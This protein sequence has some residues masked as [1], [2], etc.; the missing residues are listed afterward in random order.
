MAFDVGAAIVESAPIELRLEN[1]VEQALKNNPGLKAEK[2]RLKI[3]SGR[4]Q[5]AKRLF[6]LN[7]ELTLD[8]DYRQR[9]FS[10]PSGKSGTDFELRLLQE[11]ELSG[12]RHH[13]TE[14][15]ENYLEAAEWRF[16]ETQRQLRLRVAHLFYD[17]LTLQEKIK[18]QKQRLAVHE[19]LFNA[20]QLRF[21]QEDI[22]VLEIDTLR[23]DREQVRH[24]LLQTKAKKLVIEK[25]LSSS[26]GLNEGAAFV[27][28]GSLSTILAAQGME[29][30]SPLVEIETCALKHRP[31]LKAIQASLEGDNGAFQLALSQKVPNLSFGPLFKSDNQDT[32]I[33]ASLIIPLP[34]FNR[35]QQEVTESRVNLDVKKIALDTKKREIRREVAATYRRLK[36]T[37]DRFD[38][39]GKDY[40][41]RLKERMALPQK[42]YRAGEISIFE[43]SVAQGRLVDA[44][45]RYFDILQ[46]LLKESEDL[47]SQM[48]AC[49]PTNTR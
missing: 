31:D 22:S 27:V 39:Y 2:Q 29:I 9:K 19:D 49:D 42:A 45:L 12:Q 35:N 21:Q 43:F 23:F 44:Q 25:A 34:F 28:T 36:L 20:G 18:I 16:T 33:G 24:D 41:A 1:A 6:Q 30:S 40:L 47:N 5:Q 32:V 11:I 38:Y 8:A 4:L 48:G 15:A 46:T 17:L 10:S 13:R 14:A 37:R 7:P 26:I 3:N